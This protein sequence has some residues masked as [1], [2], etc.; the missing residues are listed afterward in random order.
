MRST[1]TGLALA[2]SWLTVLPVRGPRDIGRPE[3]RRAIAAAPVVG[4]VLG[5][6]A[7][8]L[9]WLLQWGRLEPAL[10][11]LLTVGALAL[12]TRGMHID[13]LADTA[14]GL[15]CYGPP[16][17]AR[18]I[19]HS[20]SA[21]PFGVIALVVTIGV[22][23]LAFGTLAADSSWFAVAVA[24][25]A[26]RVAV[27]FAC[28]RGIPASSEHG[29]GALVAGSQSSWAAAMW[30]TALVVAAAWAVPDRWW[31]GPLVVVVALAGAVL[32]V[33][34]CVRRFEGINGDVLGAAVEF[35][36]AATA[37]GFLLG[38]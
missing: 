18:Q 28:R 4:A 5:A 17:R 24:L 36:V 23:A 22:Q 32:L 26:G 15:G 27:V 3:G 38:G 9:L 19:M 20:G 12:V 37:V 1:V 25:I 11:G 30:G 33:R 34:H 35:T 2:L 7:V 13:G 29:F 21:G 6:I 10:A 8:G 14:D 16:E 31:Q